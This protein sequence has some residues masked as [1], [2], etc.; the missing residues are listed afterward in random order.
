MALLRIRFSVDAFQGSHDNSKGDFQ[1]QGPIRQQLL[2]GGTNVDGHFSPKDEDTPLKVWLEEQRIISEK[3]RKS[4]GFRVFLLDANGFRN[5]AGLGSSKTF[6]PPTYSV[7]NPVSE[8]R[9]NRQRRYSTVLG[10]EQ[11]MY[12][13]IFRYME[14]AE[15]IA[16]TDIIRKKVE[17]ARD[18]IGA[19]RVY[20]SIDYMLLDA[21][22]DGVIVAVLTIC[23]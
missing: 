12:V 20:T 11:S 3:V 21:V 15:S 7:L 22:I 9:L 4:L 14:S 16:A 10:C 8:A 5:P 2:G 1:H 13:P 6:C 18:G 23:T 17:K 19:K